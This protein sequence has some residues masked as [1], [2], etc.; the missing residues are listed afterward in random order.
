[1]IHYIVFGRGG[2]FIVTAESKAHAIQLVMIHT[3]T[4]GQPTWQAN[5]LDSYSQKTRAELIA[6]SVAL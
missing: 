2:S 4:I 5:P 6:E 1:M 3:D